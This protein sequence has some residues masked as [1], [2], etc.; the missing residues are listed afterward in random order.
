MN[1][2]LKDWLKR[3]GYVPK[4]SGKFPSG[5]WLNKAEKILDARLEKVFQE[6]RSINAPLP[7][8]HHLSQSL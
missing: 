6:N 8:I 2:E 5:H 3:T 4:T 7:R 1:D